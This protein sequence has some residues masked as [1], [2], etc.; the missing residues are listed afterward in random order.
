MHF[1]VDL[2][3][4]QDRQQAQIPGPG[5]YNDDGN[6]NRRTYNLKFLNFKNNNDSS[7]LQVK[8]SLSN[9]PAMFDKQNRSQS[10]HYQNSVDKNASLATKAS[11]NQ[12]TS[13]D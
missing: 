7:G 9:S 2:R 12:N 5:T 4:K 8:E 3:F 1:G 10:L 13:G 6:W 11:L